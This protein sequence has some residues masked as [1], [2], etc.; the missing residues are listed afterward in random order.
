M[1][2]PDVGFFLDSAGVVASSF[3]DAGVGAGVG[4]VASWGI[5]V[6]GGTDTRGDR[7]VEALLLVRGKTV[8][9]T[10]GG[11]CGGYG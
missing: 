5:E 9:A 3:D 4:A 2:D 8:G 11:R 10:P 7:V 1:P 6:A